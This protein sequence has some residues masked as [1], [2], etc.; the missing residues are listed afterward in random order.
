MSRL[1]K[2]LKN[3]QCPNYFIPECNLFGHWTNDVTVKEASRIMTDLKDESILGRWFVQN[4]ITGALRDAGVL[5][6]EDK[7]FNLDTN[8]YQLSLNRVIIVAWWTYLRS[9][10]ASMAK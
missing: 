1:V 10:W 8:L 6:A 5:R 2:W 4:Y 7:Q 3:K 9:I